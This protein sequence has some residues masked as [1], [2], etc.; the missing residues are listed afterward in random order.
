MMKKEYVAPQMEQHPLQ[1]FGT[2]ADFNGGANAGD[3]D[4]VHNS[5]GYD[6]GTADL[7]DETED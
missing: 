5:L 1:I 4:A 7:D 6:E 2:I 3:L